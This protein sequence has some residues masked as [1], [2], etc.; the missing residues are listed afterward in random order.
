MAQ[1]QVAQLPEAIVEFIRV[2]QPKYPNQQAVL[3]PALMEVQ[4]WYGHVAPEMA[5][6]VSEATG[7]AYAEVESVIS[8]YTMLLERPT[9][10]FVIGVCGTWN[11]EHAGA[12]QLVEHFKSKYGT[13]LNETTPDGL[14]TVAL[15]ECLCDCHNAPSAQFMKWGRDFSATWT[16]NMTVEVFDAILEDVAAG[17]QDALRERLVRLEDKPNPPDDNPWV[18]LVTTRNQ[19]PAWIEGEGDALI[20]HDGFGK[21]EGIKQDNPQF[22]QEIAAAF[23]AL[24]K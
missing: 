2:N 15:A 13:G 21:L 3:I 10:R 11:C 8:F 14:F 23:A 5:R 17:K 1:V 16:N 12:K 24:K 18:W 20:V 6:A 22:H 7:V 4:K 9:G 19:Y